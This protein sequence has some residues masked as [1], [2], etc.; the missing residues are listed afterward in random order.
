MKKRLK[1]ILKWTG[2]TFLVLLL[3]L[4]LIPII[5]K[6]QIKEMVVDEVNKNLNAELSV[7][8]FDLTFISTF[9]NMTVELYDTKLVGKDKFKGV[10]LVK[11]KKMSANVGFW[12]VIAGDQ[13]EVNEIHIE[14]PIIDIRILEDGFANY[15]IVKSDDEKTKED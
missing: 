13:V 8:D 6:N 15:D 10:E 1:K 7:G 11:M 12:S 4:I 2:I 5:F 14:K 9:P 3:A